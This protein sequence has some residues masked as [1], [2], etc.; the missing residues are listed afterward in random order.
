MT[1][2][3]TAPKREARFEFGKNWR[4]F[5][6]TLDK[7]RIRTAEASLSEMLDVEDLTGQRVLDI[8][9]GSGL[10]SLAA[11]NLG[12]QVHS[13]DYDTNSVACTR[14]LRS[15]YHAEDRRWTVEQGSVLDQEYVESLGQF[16]VVYSWGV[17]HHTGDMWAAIELAASRVAENGTL[18]IALY[19]DQD[20][21][22]SFWKRIK[23]L[24]CSGTFGKALVLS[25][26][27]PLYVA[28]TLCVCVVRRRN[29]FAEYKQSRG[30]SMVHDW[31][32]WLGGLPF[33][34]AKVEDVLRF[35]QPKGFVLRN[36][37]TTNRLGN[38]QFVFVRDA[39]ALPVAK[40]KAA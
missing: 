20:E 40:G 9:S 22:S 11:R 8:G 24:Y 28:R 25:C 17:L 14:E 7:D 30:M 1:T 19:N 33:E 13:F 32:D 35:L 21:I 26:F 39:A 10:F 12:A 23:Q 3:S 18:F 31:I 16:D 5:L 6:K 2:N 29:V 27:L 38:N 34:V 15:R 36:L 4:S 37:K